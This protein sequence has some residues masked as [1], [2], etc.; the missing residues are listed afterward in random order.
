[1]FKTVLQLLNNFQ[2]TGNFTNDVTKGYIINMNYLGSRPQ[3]QSYI[4]T[5]SPSPL[6]PTT[7]LS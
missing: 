4:L 2:S 5:K 7:I 3:F 6:L 1:M